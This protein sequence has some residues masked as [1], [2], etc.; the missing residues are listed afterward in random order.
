MGQRISAIITKGHVDVPESIVHFA[1]DNLTI[2]V[3]DFGEWDVS[4]LI[5][6]ALEFEQFDSFINHL[7]ETDFMV[8]D[9]EGEYYQMEQWIFLVGLVESL[10]LKSWF[11]EFYSEWGDSPS[12]HLFMSIIDNNIIKESCI[13]M[14]NE[15][16]V[17]YSLISS[18]KQR[19]GLT[20]SWFAN[21]KRYFSY[22]HAKRDYD[23][24]IL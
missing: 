17:D 16:E 13:H 3:L 5:E 4:D 8:S 23:S 20:L 9:D 6:A 21:E 14:W 19:M 18:T 7:K 1:Q 24:K 11:I 12:N 2:I 10:Q 15:D 22:E